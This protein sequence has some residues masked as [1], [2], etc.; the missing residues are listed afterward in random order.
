MPIPKKYPCA[1]ENLSSFGNLILQGLQEGKYDILFRFDSVNERLTYFAFPREDGLS[2]IILSFYPDD[3]SKDSMSY[4][5]YHSDMEKANQQALAF[6]ISQWEKKKSPQEL[7]AIYGPVLKTVQRF[8]KASKEDIRKRNVLRQSFLKFSDAL[9]KEVVRSHEIVP[10]DAPKIDLEFSVQEHS[11][12]RNYPYDLEADILFKGKKY[13][14]GSFRSFIEA[15]EKQE[16]YVIRTTHIPLSREGFAQDLLPVL[17]WI[18]RLRT[19][20]TDSD[21]YSY[22]Y[23]SYYRRRGNDSLPIDLSD[24]HTFLRMIPGR[25]IDLFNEGRISIPEPTEGDIYFNADGSLVMEPGIDNDMERVAH[26]MGKKAFVLLSDDMSAKP[27]EIRLLDFDSEAKACLYAFFAQ[28]GTDSLDDVKDLFPS[29]ILPYSKTTLSR[30]AEAEERPLVIRFYAAMED[31]SLVFKTEYLLRGDKAQRENIQGNPYFYDYLH[32]FDELLVQCGAVEEGTVTDEER[33][34]LFLTADLSSLKSLAD[35]F[36]DEKLSRLK[37]EKV[38]NISVHFSSGI[39]WLSATLDSQDYSKEELLEILSAYKKKKKFTLLKDKCVLLDPETL[40]EAN[41]TIKDLHLG[42]E[43]EN[44]RLPFYQAFALSEGKKGHIQFQ[45]DDYLRKAVEDI[46]EFRNR[47]L[48]LDP[49]L[50]SSLRD[51]QKDGVRWMQTLSQYH[52]CGILADDMGLGKTLET[53]AYISTLP[54]DMNSLIV[55]PKSLVYNWADELQRWLPGKAFLILDGDKAQRTARIAS[56]GLRKGVVYLLSYD[57]LRIEQESLSKKTFGLVVIDEAQS[58]KNAKALKARAVKSLQAEYRFALTGTPIE[59]ALSDMWSIFDF[60]MPDYLGN[61]TEFQRRFEGNGDDKE[62]IALLQAKVKPFVLRRTKE[63]VLTFLPPK[64][65]ITIPLEMMPEQRKIYQAYLEK[66]R[67]TFGVETS[68]INFLAALTRLRQICVDPSSFLE[69]VDE[70]S[71]K[72]G[73]AMETISQAVENGHK[74]LVFSSFTK[75]LDHLR[76]LLSGEHIASYTISGETGAS[77]RVQMADRF[78]TREDVPVMLVS[79]K[80]GGTGLNLQGADIVI[81]LDPWW[82]ASAEEQAGDRAYR[83]GQ[84]RPVTVYK[85]LCRDSIEEKVQALQDKKREL[86]KDVVSVGEN[87][88][89]KL[90]D[91][92]IK[93]LL[94]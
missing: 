34:L 58:I 27:T 61:H 15:M 53:I 49:S 68:A 22:S 7:E 62:A 83:I 46:R 41:R 76:F 32:H 87:A 24:L 47:E 54:E 93:F 89:S 78:N 13:P 90:T 9:K 71:V 82:N 65:T 2:N 74:I 29:R 75:V 42:K 18:G 1:K 20:H 79:L 48:N 57:M 23:S 51:Y 14:I 66:A 25:K 4:T 16:E 37:V 33:I 92:D 84:K 64:T 43:L 91:E 45:L 26:Y 86:Y 59:N 30:K 69:K 6:Y 39:D 85:F 12:R 73:T 28:E 56:I 67:N 44:D 60:L 70:I 17:D 77:L 81:H 52:L 36:L 10:V 63:D 88:I 50:L 40:E 8:S 19:F 94:S 3:F 55:A 21:S 80:A 35:V 72:L 38:Q 11:Y 5:Y 31:N